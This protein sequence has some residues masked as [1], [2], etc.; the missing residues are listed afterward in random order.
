VLFSNIY[1]GINAAHTA[2][3]INNMFLRGCS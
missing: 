3:N 1:R 2:R